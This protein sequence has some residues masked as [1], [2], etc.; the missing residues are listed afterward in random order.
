M[1]ASRSRRD[2]GA[3]GDVAALHRVAEIVQ[4]LGDAGHAD[5]ADA[6]EM[7][8]ADASGS[9]LMRRASM[10]TSGAIR[11]EIGEARGGIGA[12]RSRGRGGPR[13]RAGSDEQAASRAGAGRRP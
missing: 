13:Q 9:A 12:G 11:D 1:P 3:L 4:H 5:A 6:D 8:G 7:D 10:A 2:I